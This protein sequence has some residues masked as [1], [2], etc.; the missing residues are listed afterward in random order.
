MICEASPTPPRLNVSPLEGLKATS[1]R[2]FKHWTCGKGRTDQVCFQ[3][4]GR[5]ADIRQLVALAVRERDVCTAAIHSG[6]PCIVL[7]YDTLQ[8]LSSAQVGML[9]RMLNH[10]KHAAGAQG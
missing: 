3:L 1:A 6:S 9:S 7:V 2:S 10:R 5:F 4:N 8:S